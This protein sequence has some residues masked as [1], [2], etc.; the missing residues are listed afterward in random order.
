LGE[1]AGK[2]A[3]ESADFWNGDPDIDAICRMEHAPVCEFDEACFPIASNNPVPFN[4][5]KH[6]LIARGNSK[7]LSVPAYRSNG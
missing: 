7:L 5:Q 6:I 4:S 2:E 3:A 1:S